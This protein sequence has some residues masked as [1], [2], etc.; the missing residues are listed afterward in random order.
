MSPENRKPSDKNT[1]TPS[2]HPSQNGAN[3]TV[4]EQV[5]RQSAY[6]EAEKKSVDKYIRN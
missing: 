6:N 4:N 3:L 2:E 5:K 1:P